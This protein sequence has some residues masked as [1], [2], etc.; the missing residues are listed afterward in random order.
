MVLV[1]R[2][3]STLGEMLAMPNLKKE[4][5]ANQVPLMLPIS[6]A[7]MKGDLGYH[8]IITLTMVRAPSGKFQGQDLFR[9]LHQ[10][11]T[12]CV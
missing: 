6:C 7:A 12:A 1:R 4:E 11:L 3:L 10:L 2:S 5:L 9:S 8:L